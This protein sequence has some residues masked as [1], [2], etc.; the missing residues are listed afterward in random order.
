MAKNWSDRG[1]A[2]RTLGH[3]LLPR[4]RSL[5]RESGS[6]LYLV[7]GVV[8]DWARGVEV[9][10]RDI[11]LVSSG[12]ISVLAQ[13]AAKLFQGHPFPLDRDT[14]RI[15]FFQGEDRWRMDLSPL[16]GQDLPSDL[17][18]RDFTINAMA[19]EIAEG[20]SLPLHD[21]LRGG[22]DLAR[23]QIR[24]CSPRSFQED[25]LRLLR[26]VRFSAQM[27][28]SIERETLQGLGAVSHLL[29]EVSRERVRDEFFKILAQGGS[30]QHIRTLKELGLLQGVLPGIDIGAGI[31]Q[32]SRHRWPLW[33]HSLK[34]LEE[35]ESIPGK[36]DGLLPSWSSALR[37]HLD[38]SLEEGIDARL[39]LRFVALLHDVGKPLTRTEDETGRIRFFGHEERGRE[40]MA[41]ICNSLRIGR[42][43]RARMETL[44][45]SH[46]RPLLL[47]SEECW[48]NRAKYRLFR[49]LG[50]LGI[51]LLLLGWA[52]LRAT[53]EERHPH[54]ERYHSFLREMISYHYEA[55]SAQKRAPLVRG[56]DIMEFLD[57]PSG[58]LIGLLLE[59]V[60][61]AE[62]EGRFQTREAGLRYLKE[63][64]KDWQ[65][66][67][68]DA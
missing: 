58:P 48:T 3:Q 47:A 46:L 40:Q 1:P 13:R 25:P 66:A 54:L 45:G 19:L 4:L 5:C 8:R 34:A 2:W 39:T 9:G 16:R 61:E 27:G 23:R 41:E 6:P 21:P 36:I 35:M 31:T 43:A 30:A 20:E 50:E 44:V 15:V 62:A 65:R 64:W 10:D 52:D 57:L 63:H 53:V 33:E 17:A 7:G 14:W 59:R 22:E 24:W 29:R 42:R 49:D 18:R 60:A 32:G 37:E 56:R 11:D 38:Q 55:F 67:R 26:A 68:D 51:D 28:F 12:Q